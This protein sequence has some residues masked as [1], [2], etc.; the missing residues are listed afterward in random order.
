MSLNIHVAVGPPLLTKYIHMASVI[1]STK[2]VTAHRGGS[3]VLGGPLLPDPC[4]QSVRPH[5]I[6]VTYPIPATKNHL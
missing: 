1:D 5:I 6:E 3:I 2:V 4:A